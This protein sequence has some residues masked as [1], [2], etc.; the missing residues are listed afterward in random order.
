M[1]FEV[2]SKLE[3]ENPGAFRNLGIDKQDESAQSRSFILYLQIFPITKDL[4]FSK[5]SGS[6]PHLLLGLRIALLDLGGHLHLPVLQ[7][8]LVLLA[9]VPRRLV[10][11]VGRRSQQRHIAGGLELL[12]QVRLSCVRSGARLSWA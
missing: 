4:S 12:L 5:R 10:I 6:G 7:H 2:A 3:V 9:P 11:E 8:L 1:Q